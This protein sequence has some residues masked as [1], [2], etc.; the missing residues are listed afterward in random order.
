MLKQEI[1]MEIYDLI[2]NIEMLD[3]EEKE[4]WKKQM[5]KHTKAELIEMLEEGKLK[6]NIS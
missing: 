4:S 5:S 2:D 3:E 6:N 1:L